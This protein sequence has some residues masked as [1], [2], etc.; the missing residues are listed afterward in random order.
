MPT[1]RFSNILY[2]LLVFGKTSILLIESGAYQAS[3]TLS[4]KNKRLVY[5]GLVGLCL[6]TNFLLA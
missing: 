5:F 2:I 1:I 6:E 4:K 3:F